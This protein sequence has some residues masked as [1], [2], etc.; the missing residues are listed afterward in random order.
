MNNDDALIWNKDLPFDPDEHTKKLSSL[1]Q[2]SNR[3]PPQILTL[4]PRCK[5]T[6]EFHLGG[7]TW[8]KAGKYA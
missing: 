3:V 5:H 4:N 6:M 7:K 8:E 2:F 1:Y